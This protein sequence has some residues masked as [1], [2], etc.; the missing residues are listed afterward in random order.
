MNKVDYILVAAVSV[1]S[2]FII[3]KWKNRK[4]KINFEEEILKL[5]KKNNFEEEILNLKN[6]VEFTIDKIGK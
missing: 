6:A 3:W 5:E 2:F 4:K 1:F